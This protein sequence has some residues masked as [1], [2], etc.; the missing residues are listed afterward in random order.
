MATHIMHR[1]SQ[2]PLPASRHVCR[3]N[4]AAVSVH[5]RDTTVT[6]VARADEP[7]PLTGSKK[8]AASRPHAGHSSDEVSRLRGEKLAKYNEDWKSDMG[9]VASPNNEISMLALVVLG[10]PLI[11]FAIAAAMYGPIWDA[12]IV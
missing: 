5:P 1:L 8:L 9:A 3:R 4:V 6:R 10:V 7:Q 12:G 11:G 2:A